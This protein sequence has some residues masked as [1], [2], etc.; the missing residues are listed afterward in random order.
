MWDTVL[1]NSEKKSLVRFLVIYLGSTFFLFGIAMWIF[2]ASTKS[3]ILS[4]QTQSLKQEALYIKSKLREL[5]LLEDEKLI[6]PKNNNIDSAIYDLDKKYIFGTFKKKPLLEDLKSS[7]K[8]YYISKVE[9]FY[10]GAAYLLVTKKI[11]VKPIESL[12]KKIFL[13]MVGTGLF[14]VVLGYYLG[15]LFVAP[16][17]R[18]IEQMNRFIQDTAHELN[19]PVSTILTNIEMIE[20][21]SKHKNDATELKR[22][23]IASKTLSRIYDDLV[24]LNLN[25]EYHR[26]IEDLNI[27]KLIQERIVYFAGM[28]DVKNIEIHKDIAS[29]VILKMDR[30]DALRV[31]DNLISN[32]I[33]YNNINGRIKIVLTKEYFS[34]EDSGIGI[35]KGD[36]KKIMQRFKRVNDSEGGFG[37]GL[38]IVGQVVRSYGFKL[39]IDSK[40]GHG[41]KVKIVWEK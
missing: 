18:S 36:I 1:L 40:E 7:D 22:I 16:M 39:F 2:Y 12:E 23:E 24:Y 9:P 25:H 19:T 32:A 37:I 20:T 28:V 11:D 13:F 34:V 26:R 17:K 5:H 33:K 35:K 41:T 29:D 21:L 38:D 6:Y 8:L 3:H 15:K 27:G 10:L 31:I 4:Q 30:N 14:L